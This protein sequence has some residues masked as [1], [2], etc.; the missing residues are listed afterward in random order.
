VDRYST[1]LRNSFP[2]TALR[3]NKAVREAIGHCHDHGEIATDDRKKKVMR[4]KREDIFY[5]IKTSRWDLIIIGGG[6]TGAGIMREAARCGLNTLLVEQRDFSWGTSSRSG[7]LVHGGL[8]YM[9]QGDFGLTYK[10]VKERR[11]LLRELPGLVKS[12]GLMMA[13]YKEGWIDRLIIRSALFVYDI[14][15]RN[16]RRHK[17]SAEDVINHAPDIKPGN[18]ACGLLFFESITD[19]ARLVFRV[20]QQAM[21]DG[22]TALNYCRVSDLLKNNGRVTGVTLEDVITENKLNVRARQV[23]NATGVWV[24]SLRG[25]VTRINRKTIRPLR[26]SHLVLSADRLPITKSIIMT[27]PTSG[28]PGFASPWEGRILVG[29]TDIDHADDLDAEAAISPEEVGYLLEN[30]RHHFP[31][32]GIDKTDIIATFSGVRPVIGT[33]KKNPSSE[34]RDHAVWQEDGLLTVT[35][36]KLTTFRLIALDA[37]RKTRTSLGALPDLGKEHPFFTPLKET[38]PPIKIKLNNKTFERLQGRYGNRVMELI[39]AAKEGE[40]DEIPGTQTLWAELRWAAKHEMVVHLE[41]L[42]LRRTRI[43]LLLC[44]GGEEYL[45]R[46]RTICQMELGWDDETWLREETRYLDTW[47]RFYGVPD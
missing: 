23:I 9:K 36:G 31:G 27:H 44:K 14:M 16:F 24:D 25:H 29:N 35:G 11:R 47:R 37:L 20:L 32:L 22:G 2:P 43:A 12:F 39:D 10:S 1:W 15:S 42:M 45:P 4:S 38:N 19:D 46:I 13:L 5:K 17:Y 30:L 33:G 3:E 18:L 40:L 8:R 7:Q 6:I 34:S 26:G 21:E 41:D 28:R